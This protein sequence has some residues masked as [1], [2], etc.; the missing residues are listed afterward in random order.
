LRYIKTI[1]VIR[2]SPI[3]KLFCFGQL[4]DGLCKLVGGTP[5]AGSL[6]WGPTEF[7]PTIEAVL[8]IL[9]MM[10]APEYPKFVRHL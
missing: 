9:A 1:A 7:I 5:N 3:A 10:G 2:T 6:L 8:P 4:G